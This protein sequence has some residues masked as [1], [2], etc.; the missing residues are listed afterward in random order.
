MTG[1]RPAARRAPHCERC[2]PGTPAGSSWPS[3][4]GRP[5]PWR[6]CGRRPT[7]SCACSSRRRCRRSG[8]W[9]VDFEPTSDAEIER[10]AG[11][12]PADP[13][14]RRRLARPRGA[15]PGGRRSSATSP[16]PKAARGLVVFAHGSGSSRSARATGRSPRAL[17]ERGLATLLL[18]LLTLRRNATARNVFDITLLPQRLVAATRWART[19]PGSPALPVGYFGAS[20]GAGGGA[21]GRGRARGG[22]RRGR[23]ARRTAGPGR[24]PAGGRTRAGAADRRR[25]RRGRTRAEPRGPAPV[26]GTAEL[27]VVPG[28]THLFEEPGALEEVSRLAGAWFEQNLKPVGSRLATATPHVDGP[29]RGP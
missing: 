7:R 26:D 14:R 18:D 10:A 23:L 27:A 15:D 9:Y 8:L 24:R 22:G 17:N 25:A 21:V 6:R 2:A 1:W 20:T 3:R 19:E 5:R 11:G 28:A 4:S 16:F 12:E 29:E 13:P